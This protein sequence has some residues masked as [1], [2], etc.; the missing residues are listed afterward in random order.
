MPNSVL[1]YHLYKEKGGVYKHTCHISLQAFL[2]I[3]IAKVISEEEDFHQT[4][5][6]NFNL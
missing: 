5:Y 1:T 2:E 3:E 6:I 4:S